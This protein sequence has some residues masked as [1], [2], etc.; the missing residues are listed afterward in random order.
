MRDCR[1]WRLTSCSTIP[2][3]EWRS[4]NRI[5]LLYT[6][7]KTPV[8]SQPRFL[9]V[10]SSRQS[11]PCLLIQIDTSLTLLANKPPSSRDTHPPPAFHRGGICDFKSS[12]V[13]W[14][15]ARSPSIGYRDR[16]PPTFSSAA[17]FLSL[18]SIGLLFISSLWE[19]IN[20]VTQ[21]HRRSDCVLELFAS[22]V[23]N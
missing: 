9:S 4:C 14:V 17:G 12:V 10:S 16:R 8:Q 6:V 18:I 3:H 15:E 13:D 11:E 5:D 19:M 7:S 20:D 22:P 21:T 1:P 2:E 23:H